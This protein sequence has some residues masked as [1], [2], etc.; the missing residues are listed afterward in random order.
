[1][2]FVLLNDTCK[3]AMACRGSD[4]YF[5]LTLLFSYTP[6]ADRDLP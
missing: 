4:S 2:S 1:M 6:W 5:R 3:P